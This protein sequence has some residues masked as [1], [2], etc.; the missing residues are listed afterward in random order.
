MILKIK[1]VRDYRAFK[2]WRWP[3]ELSHFQQINLVYGVNGTGKSTIAC[4]LQEA[5]ADSAWASGL[6]VDVTVSDGKTRSVS[7]A[8]DGLW[9]DVHVFNKEYVATNLQFDEQAGSAAA[10]LLVLGERQVEAETER[11]RIQARL[12]ETEAELPEL[13]KAQR[14]AKTKYEKIATDRARLIAEE[15][16][17]VGGRYASRSYT[18]AKVRQVIKNGV[19]ASA[20]QR[21]ISKELALVRSASKAQLSIP[22]TDEF[23]LDELVNDTKQVMEE[24]AISKVL[25]ELEDVQRSQWVQRGLELHGDQKECIFCASQISAERRQALAEHFDTSL[26][27]L[28]KR[29][30]TLRQRLDVLRDDASKAVDALPR[31]DDFFEPQQEEYK[32]A[33]HNAKAALDEFLK[34]C[35]IVGDAIERKQQALFT[36]CAYDWPDYGALSLGGITDLIEQ[37]NAMANDFDN[38][39]SAAAKTVETVRVAE[40]VDEYQE[41]EAASGASCSQIEALE[42]EQ[43]QLRKDL[44]GLDGGNLDAAPIAKQ[45]ND[46]LTHLLGRSDLTFEVEGQGYRIRREGAPARHLSEGERNAISLLYFLRS[47]ETH[48]TRAANAIIVIDDPVSSLD[49]STLVGASTHLWTRLV[50]P[51]KCRQLFLL[52]H[53][54]ELFRLWASHLEHYPKRRDVA[55]TYGVY[56]LRTG[57]RDDGSGKYRRAPIILAWPDDPK[58]QA[59]LRSEYHYLFWRVISALRDCVLEPSA[60]SDIEAA[61]VLP[62]V[63][64]RL[65]EGFLGFKY[66]ALLGNL[67]GQIMKASDGIISEA[68]RAR[69]LRFAHAYSHNQEA[70]TTIP[71]ARPEAVDMLHVVLE[72]MEIIDKSHFQAMCEAVDVK[73]DFLAGAPN[74]TGTGL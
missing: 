21:D 14:N 49:G 52:T 20:S 64:R 13:R 42:Q 37:H 45:L 73:S 62:N 41:L 46:D 29:L 51:T 43:L 59:R 2:D 56:E 18:A 34:S 26:V 65:L 1:H 35:D 50:G 57:V 67:H 23:S 70:D 16:A 47:L 60:Q 36:P 71:V 44:A 8:S 58:V 17:S 48:E 63:C 32:V 68:M 69:V 19:D 53:N 40:I 39:Q 3:T 24:S 27:E 54:F 30:S 4:L 61:T 28:Q 7:S 15:L 11:T 31:I 66:P 25:A 72:F 22:S 38:Q 33:A 6:Q 5:Q 55:I 10:P 9:R 74:A 12:T